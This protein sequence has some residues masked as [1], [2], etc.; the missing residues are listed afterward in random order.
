MRSISVTILKSKSTRFPSFNPNLKNKIVSQ[1]SVKQPSKTTE[2]K[3]TTD[4]SV[5]FGLEWNVNS[6]LKSTSYV[7]SGSDSI[8]KFAR[9]LIPGVFVTKTWQKHGLTFSF[10][11]Y[12]SYFG[13]TK[14]ISQQIDSTLSTDSLKGYNNVRLIKAVGMNF[15]LQYQYHVSRLLALNVGASYSMFSGALF[16]EEI[17]TAMGTTIPGALVT[18]KNSTEIRT[19]INPR[20]F[21]L[22]AGISFTPGRFQVGLNVILPLSSVSKS[23][24]L[25]VKALNGQF[26]LRFLVW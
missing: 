23:S 11:P 13:D 12:Q 5:H 25:P 14:M 8:D 3:I 4:R 15:S 2:R 7:L 17:Q 9:L 18:L 22:K 10:S 16:R 20:L 21:A 19:K 1:N 6:S 26:Y 24:E